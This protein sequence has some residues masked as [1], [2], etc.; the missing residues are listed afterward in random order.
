MS[1]FETDLEKESQYLPRIWIRYVD[2]IFAIF[3]NRKSKLEHFLE[4]LNSRFTSIKLVR[5]R[6]EFL[7]ELVS[8]QQSNNTLEIDVTA[9]V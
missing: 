4:T 3:D 2:D 5:K 6:R 9:K 7:D 8:R 1:R